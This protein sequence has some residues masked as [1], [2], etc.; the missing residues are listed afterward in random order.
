MRLIHCSDFCC[1]IAIWYDEYLVPGEKFND[2]IINAMRTSDAFALAVTPQILEDGN[3]VLEH[4]YPDAIKM[5]KRVLPFEMQKTDVDRL[6]EKFDGLPDCINGNETSVAQYM[7]DAIWHMSFTPKKCDS[8]HNFFIGLVY[9]NGINVERDN[10]RAIALISDV[11]NNDLLEAMAKMVSIY[12]KAEG[13]ERDYKLALAWQQRYTARMNEVMNEDPSSDN[14]ARLFLTMSNFISYYIELNLFVEAKK[15]CAQVKHLGLTYENSS[16]L[17][18][19]LYMASR[20]E[21]CL[22]AS[23]E[24]SD[25]PENCT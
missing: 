25:S 10:K 1:D 21:Q 16:M 17:L 2:A 23:G 18:Y 7:S 8:V 9:L 4:E 3:Y 13:V 19:S 11:A 6:K 20:I 5:G 12:R 15:E 24:N 14:R 22:T